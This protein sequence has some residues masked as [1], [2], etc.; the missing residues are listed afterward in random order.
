MP[1]VLIR[2]LDAQTIK[3]LKA[4]AKRHGRSFQSEAKLA[5]ERAAGASAEDVAAI[6]D[7]WQKHFNG[8]RFSDSAGLIR[9]D[10]GR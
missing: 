3:R 4:R 10:R 9:E 7:K 1:D 6:L 5:L 2:D 8:R